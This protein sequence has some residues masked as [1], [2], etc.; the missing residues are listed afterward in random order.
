[1]FHICRIKMKTLIFVIWT[2][3]FGLLFLFGQN[4]T[5]MY[6]NSDLIQQT[7]INPNANMGLSALEVWLRIWGFWHLNS[8]FSSCFVM[9]LGWTQN[10]FHELFPWIFI[11]LVTEK[12]YLKDNSPTVSHQILSYS[13]M[14]S[15]LLYCNLLIDCLN[16]C[17]PQF[18]TSCSMFWKFQVAYFN[19]YAMICVYLVGSIRK[20]MINHILPSNLE[21]LMNMPGNTVMSTEEKKSQYIESLTIAF[22]RSIK[23]IKSAN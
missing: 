23:V 10:E 6:T 2:C 17:L 18:S 11:D 12:S 4:G 21:V 9:H 5:F 15:Y 20:W 7:Q 22:N 3:L 14:L 16:W 19:L 8:G 13:Q 1:M